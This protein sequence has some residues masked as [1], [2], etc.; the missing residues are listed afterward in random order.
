MRAKQLRP[1]AAAVAALSLVTLD[2]IALPL[3]QPEIG[4]CLHA[5]TA[6]MQWALIANCLAWAALLTTGLALRTRFGDR[7]VFLAGELLLAGCC[8]LAGAAPDGLV[9]VAAR[10]G[11]GA[12]SALVVPS[13]LAQ[14]GHAFSPRLRGA[15]PSFAGGATELTA[16][17]GSLLCAAVV[18]PLGWR[19][20]FWMN[21]PVCLAACA[22][23]LAQHW[24]E[25]LP[26]RRFDAT[27]TLVFATG[28]LCVVWALTDVAGRGWIDAPV[29]AGLALG[30]ALLAYQ[31]AA[32]MPLGLFRGRE[33]TGFRVG[34]ACGCAALFGGVLVL[35][36]RASLECGDPLCAWFRLAP[37]YVGLCLSSPLSA[38]FSGRVG[39]GRQVAG[40]LAVAATGFG[41]L[42]LGFQRKAGYAELLVPLVLAGAGVVLA[43]PPARL[44]SAGAHGMPLDDRSPSAGGAL[45]LLA[46]SLGIGIVSAASGGRAFGPAPGSAGGADGSVAALLAVA[47]VCLVGSAAAFVAAARKDPRPSPQARGRSAAAPTAW[48][49]GPDRPAGP[50]QGTGPARGAGRPFLPGPQPHRFGGFGFGLGHYVLGP[51]FGQAR[52]GV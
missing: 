8:A 16:V 31:A 14:V 1:P 48:C 13:A 41:L 23:A 21:V 42:A 4:R 29:L 44:L 5:S 52:P 22:L 35:A 49:G 24:G 50:A 32:R 37:L 18:H 28:S 9:L 10:A 3:V 33:L 11:Q 17:L 26:R 12:A 40:S 25:P 51:R 2:N 27:G 36:T 38:L 15:L 43:L 39:P 46:G 45:R 47:A 6:T 7:R 19:W 34:Y 30:S 20:I